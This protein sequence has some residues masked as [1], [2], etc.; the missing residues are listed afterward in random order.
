MKVKIT[1]EA[2]TTETKERVEYFVKRFCIEN[3]QKEAKIEVEE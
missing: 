2:E 3:F 1:I